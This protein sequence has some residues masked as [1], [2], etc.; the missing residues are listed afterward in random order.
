MSW[1]SFVQQ[2][3]EEIHSGAPAPEYFG[4]IGATI[5]RCQQTNKNK[6]SLFEEY[7]EKKYK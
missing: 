2:T 6:K 4:C 1:S 7:L 3:L 5:F